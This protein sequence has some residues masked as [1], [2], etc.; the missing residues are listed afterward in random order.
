MKTGDLVVFKTESVHDRS[1]TWFIRYATNK[2][3]ML[4]VGLVGTYARLLR[5]D[6]SE[7]TMKKTTLEVINE[8]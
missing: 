8:N 4:V 7:C 3:P 6:G 5:P 2:I 1:T